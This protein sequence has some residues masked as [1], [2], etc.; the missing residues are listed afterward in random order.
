MHVNEMDK[1]G[2]INLLTL[3]G[4]LQKFPGLF[5][6]NKSCMFLE[7]N[8]ATFSVQ[9]LRTIMSLAKMQ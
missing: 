8:S 6:L 3:N 1:I 9:I 7:F 4:F 2:Y 5:C